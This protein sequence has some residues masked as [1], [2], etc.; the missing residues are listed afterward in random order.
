[1][2]NQI[3]HDPIVPAAPVLPR[4]DPAGFPSLPPLPQP[5][6]F[7]PMAP[8]PYDP[9]ADAQHPA[10]NPGVVSDVAAVMSSSINHTTIGAP[11]PDTITLPVPVVFNGVLVR[12]GRVRELTGYDEEELARA[13]NSGIPERMP[14]TLL[15]RGVVALGDTKPSP[16]DLE[17]LPVGVRDA[18]LLAI[19]T[20][21]YGSEIHFEKLRCQRC[22]KDFELRYDLDDVPTTSLDETVP[23]VVSVALRRGGRAQARFATGADTKAILAAIRDRQINRAEQDT[24]LLARTLTSL[25]DAH[26]AGIRLPNGEALD[27]ARSMSMPDRSAIL[28]ALED[29]RPGPRQEDA[30]VT[31]P[32]CEQETE[33]PLSL[34]V[35][36]RD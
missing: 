12:T 34:D 24:I 16:A 9:M 30:T 23:A 22:S 29:Q 10:E 15:Q 31:C 36:F 32:E 5:A 1:M 13:A 2:D 11:A 33:V 17:N 25:T 28:R 35:L 4:N 7:D 18:L 8:A 14:E 21:T 27:I 20:A 6:V 3:I 19:R 26:G